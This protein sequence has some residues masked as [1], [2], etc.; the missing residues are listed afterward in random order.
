MKQPKKNFGE[1]TAPQIVYPDKIA[2]S[3]CNLGFKL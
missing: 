3:G 2:Y 1:H